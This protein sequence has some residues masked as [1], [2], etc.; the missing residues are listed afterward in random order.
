MERGRFSLVYKV[1]DAK[2]NINS[3]KNWSKGKWKIK[4]HVEIISMPNG[5]LMF[6]FSN[7]NDRD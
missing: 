1:H 3:I 5:Y 2:S 6:N 4:G 7:I